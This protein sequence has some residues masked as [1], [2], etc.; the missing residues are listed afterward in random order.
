MIRL[1]DVEPSLALFTE[2]LAGQYLHIKGRDEFTGR[3]EFSGTSG[4]TS[5]TL[6]L[7]SELPDIATASG[8]RVLALQQIAQRLY[9]TYKLRLDQILQR[10]PHLSE[11]EPNPGT[12]SLRQG[13]L[14]GWY[15]LYPNPGLLAQIFQLFEATRTDARMLRQHPGMTKHYRRY[16]VDTEQLDMLDAPVFQQAEYYA[17]HLLCDA[18]TELELLP[19]D[20][21]LLQLL[22]D[23]LTAL[24]NANPTS[25]YDS[26]VAADACYEQVVALTMGSRLPATAEAVETQEDWTQRDV[27]LEDWDD[28]IAQLNQQMMA[29]QVLEEAEVD[30]ADGNAEEGDIKPDEV[31]IR[32]LTEQRDTLSRRA[33][34]ERS[35]I[36]HALGPAHPDTRSYLYDEW[37]YH[38][39]TYLRAYCRLYEERLL[40]DDSGA[41]LGEALEV[42][43]RWQPEVKARL[44]HIKPL[45][46]QRQPRVE[47]GDELDFN[48]L[49]QARLDLRTGISPDD[50]I[51]SRRERVRRDLGAAFLVDLSA[52]TDD[53][54]EKPEPEPYDLDEDGEP[55]NLRDPYLEFEPVPVEETP[56]RI[57]DVQREA[58]LVMASALESLGDDHG[59]YGFSGY[60]RDCVEFYV[61]KELGEA[62]GAQT[63]NSIGAMQPKR[64]TRMGPA[65]RHATRK[66]VAAG[67]AQK[68][69]LILS[70]GFPQDCDYGPDRGEHEYGV[71]DTAK[72]LAEAEAKGIDTFCVTVDRSGHDYLARMCPSANYLII[73]EVE[74]LPA[75]LTKVYQALAGR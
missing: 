12:M 45:G 70:D 34:M 55:L 38:Q 21:I 54:L 23:P 64:S 44:A 66:L 53:P 51:Y 60:G 74:D 19:S 65:I 40:A 30:A 22:T 9:G 3:A 10:L 13:D 46:Y 1:V 36:R 48:A 4:Q 33:E 27:R 35:A 37:D 32:S 6:Y 57:I 17:A 73:D 2:G 42:V 14:Q 25:V 29:A 20:P 31:S 50:R 69:L 71:Q 18:L 39:Q 47:D 67:Y 15:Q 5:D 49:L 59:I 62:F 16:Y 26:V 28:E 75:A 24:A 8:F 52:S 61:A 41:E 72:A 56:R 58:M 7:P 11:R 68:L 63:L 43:R